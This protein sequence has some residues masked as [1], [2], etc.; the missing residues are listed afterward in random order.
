MTTS[1]SPTTRSLTF[2]SLLVAGVRKN[3]QVSLSVALGVATATAVIVGALLVGDS[4]RG[5]LRG[6]TIERL[7]KT[8]SVVIP[9]AF[10]QIEGIADPR[11]GT[12]LPIILFSSAVVESSGDAS[13]EGSIQRAGSVQIVGCDEA[14]WQL[15]VTGVKPRAIARQVMKSC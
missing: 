5:S 13:L 3:W 9:G 4:M 12:L 14:F 2:G 1:Q 6:L 11:V 10:F 15:D 7:G 8:E